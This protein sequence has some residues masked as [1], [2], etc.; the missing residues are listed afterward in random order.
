MYAIDYFLSYTVNCMIP[1]DP[2]IHS[3]CYFPLTTASSVFIS[4]LFPIRML[5]F[6]HFPH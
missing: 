2:L 3:H 5:F 6:S 1:Y 4:L